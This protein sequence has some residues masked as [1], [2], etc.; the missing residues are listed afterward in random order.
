MYIDV[1]LFSGFPKPLLY[2]TPSTWEQIKPGTIV[3]VPMRNTIVP[4]LVLHTHTEPPKVTFEVREAKSIEAFPD[5]KNYYTYIQKLAQYHAIDE[6]QFVKRI[7]TFITQ[8]TTAELPVQE[9]SIPVKEITLTDE[10]QTV[11]DFLTPKVTEQK[12]TPTLL[13]GVTG[14]G[15]TEVYKKLI[16]HAFKQKKSVILLLPEVTLSVQFERL[17][18]AQLPIDIPIL[19]F[20]SATSAKTKKL[21]WKYTLQG[22]P[23]LIIGV[24]LPILL[25]LSNL[26]LIIVDEEHE[27]GFQEKKHPK[28]NTKH[29]ALLRAHQYN[30]PILLGSATPSITSLYNVKHRGWKLFQLKKRFAGAFP[31]IQRI[32]LTDKKQ[33][34][35]F[36]I[37]TELKNSLQDR[38]AKKEQSLV[39]LNRRG[40]CFF[41]QCKD[42]SHIF[43]CTSCSVSLT[44]HADQFLKCHY[45]SY[46]RPQPTECPECHKKE[47]VKKGIG[48]QQIVTILQRMFPHARIARADLDTTI[49]KKLW[50]QTISMF[51]KQ[52][53]DILVGT[54]TITKGYHFPNV[55]LVGVIW[56][57]INLNFP[58]YNAQETVLQQLIQVAGR[59]GRQRP[60]ST[61]IVQTMTDHPIFNYLTEVNYLKFYQKEIE[62]RR[63]VNYPPIIRFAEIEIKNSKEEVAEQE[64]F[65]I[66]A[67]LLKNKNLTVLGPAQPPVSRIKKI[68]SRKIYI[69]AKEFN[70]LVSA[71]KSLDKQQFRSSI[72]FTPHPLS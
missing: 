51:E 46:S 9:H 28:L 3:R 43:N 33:R 2:Q 42:C 39:F 17:L 25:P 18:R 45:C 8:T 10:Q 61:V 64:A 4:A 53:L 21:L 62:E 36:W 19:S 59:A 66:S 26:G 37:S 72:F 34:K 58:F 52:E 47:F 32:S 16:L 49:N 14:S 1:K 55:T 12:Y 30:I 65:T 60:D 27:S 70:Y 23:Q 40:V 29:A 69:K 71:F 15:K 7:R 22:Y 63:M 13:H 67:Q 35:N 41:M 5:D 44:L 6:I 54:Q 31:T 11:V 68:F 57:D 48:T 24:H 56:G 38:L 50:Q 20:H